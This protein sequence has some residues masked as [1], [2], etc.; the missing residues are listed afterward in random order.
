MRNLIFILGDQLSPVISSLEGFD[1]KKDAVLM[2]EVHEEASYVGHHKKKLVLIFSAMRN[3]AKEIADL[4]F[5][6]HYTK[7]DDP[8][9]QH[10]FIKELKKNI[11]QYRPQKV[12]ITEPS[13]YRVLKMFDQ[14]F[15]ENLIEYEIR[16]DTRF[17]ASHHEFANFVKEKKQLL[18]ENFYHLMRKKTGLLMEKSPKNSPNNSPLDH[19]VGGK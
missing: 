8:K 10:N 12:V 15:S 2:T 16:N 14:F 13:E 4:G 3:F 7:L 17:I 6:V 18:M 1:P 19:Q 5:T 9:N 11:E